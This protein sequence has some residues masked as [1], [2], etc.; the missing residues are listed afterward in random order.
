MTKTLTVEMSEGTYATLWNAILKT[1]DKNS[2]SLFK[3]VIR[4]IKFGDIYYY[5]MSKDLLFGFVYEI[6]K[7]GNLEKANMILKNCRKE[8]Y[9]HKYY[10]FN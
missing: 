4:K 6:E 5:T 3:E 10:T 9:H 7:S 2:L 8:G 1:G